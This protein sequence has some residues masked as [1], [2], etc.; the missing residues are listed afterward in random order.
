MQERSI[1]SDDESM[2]SDGFDTINEK[3]SDTHDLKKQWLLRK[4]KMLDDLERYSEIFGGYLILDRSGAIQYLNLECLE[5][6]GVNPLRQQGWKLSSV[7]SAESQDTFQQFLSR[8]F[9][10]GTKEYCE[11]LLQPATDKTAWI[12]ME[13]KMSRT[14]Q[15]CYMVLF[16]ITEEK[17]RKTQL[18]ANELKYRALFA[19]MSTA[20]SYHKVIRDNRG[21]C[22][23]PILLEA[24][25]AYGALLGKPIGEFIGK[26]S[27]E[28]GTVGYAP[29][30]D[31]ERLCQGV[32]VK[33]QPACFDYYD[34]N[35]KR[36][37]S[38][39]A[40]SPAPEHIALV[41]VDITKTKIAEQ[42][43][44]E[45]EQRYW[46]LVQG[47]DVIIMIINERFE[48]SFINEY[49]LSFFGFS[50][51]E[52]L[53]RSVFGTIAPV[54]DECGRNQATAFEKFKTA[55]RHQRRN[56][57]E[58]L[59]RSG[60]R[61][62]V[63]WTNHEMQDPKTGEQIVI[64]V[65]VDVTEKKRAEQ[66]LLRKHRQQRQ[67]EFLN[68]AIQKR[69]GIS[70]W[71]SSAQLMGIEIQS[72]FVLSLLEIPSDY[73]TSGTVEQDQMQ[74]QCAID[75]LIETLQYVGV[76]LTWL[77]PDGIAVLRSVPGKKGLSST[78]QA[79][80]IA[81]DI[82]KIVSRYWNG[83]NIR[84]GIS[85]TSSQA[86]DFGEMY[87]QAH[88]AITYGP[89]LHPE[90]AIHAWH[91]LGCYQFVLSDLGSNQTTQFVRDHLGPLLAADDHQELLMT[92]M[93]L[94]AGGSAQTIAQNLHVHPQTVAFRKKKIEKMLGVDLDLMD[95]RLVLTIATR[96]LSFMGKNANLIDLVV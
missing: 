8:I 70:E 38:V 46:N 10:G 87:T 93:E 31:W 84:L 69:L 91:D 64:C 40:Y 3:L 22:C 95:N 75:T 74:R 25:E 23:D 71:L 29:S 56:I 30:L 45:S 1:V 90:R 80:T 68:D 36:W 82:M 49:G 39:I 63:D 53:S 79:R 59:T 88:S 44:T 42:K 86:Q 60:R 26:N 61:V 16:N 85:R 13:G 37:L 73:L 72:P 9:A 27:S 51:D 7:L 18:A 50:E 11:V 96:L 4:T 92:L 6:F 21:K 66:E 52:L 19:N 35:L 41:Y 67:K 15:Y 47:T 81:E 94:L 33:N 12:R 43:V 17:R 62:W 58:N 77:A 32:V 65:G 5:I 57:Q 14:R 76:G 78:E 2:Q 34:K 20:F 28:I 54:C 55:Q 24:N 83:M 48:I 89:I